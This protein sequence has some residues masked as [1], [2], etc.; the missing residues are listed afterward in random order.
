MVAIPVFKTPTIIVMN[1]KRIDGTLDR[2]P[3]GETVPN[4]CAIIGAAML[5]AQTPVSHR[6]N[7]HRT[8]R[9]DIFPFGSLGPRI[10]HCIWGSNTQS[11]V[12]TM[13]ES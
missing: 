9:F 5:H 3:L 2:I 1:K 8:E 7:I 12:T 11:A 10:L 13:N 6:K 4:T